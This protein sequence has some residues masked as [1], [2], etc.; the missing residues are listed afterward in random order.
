MITFEEYHKQMNIYSEKLKENFDAYESEVGKYQERYMNQVAE[1][2]ADAEEGT[3][4]YYVYEILSY[5]IRDS[6]SGNVVE[7]VPTE[8]LADEVNELLLG[9]LGDYLLEAPDI[10]ASGDGWSVNCMFGGY[11]TPYWDG[12]NE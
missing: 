11:Y 2:Y 3:A 6:T 12:W 8:E 1:K 5:L 10:Y 4:P 7:E 9:E